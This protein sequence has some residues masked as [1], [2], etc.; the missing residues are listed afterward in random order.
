MLGPDGEIK[1]KSGGF[2]KHS[3]IDTDW[4]CYSI[5]ADGNV[6]VLSQLDK[7]FCFISGMGPHGK[8]YYCGILTN[9]W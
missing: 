4:L 1:G 6:A 9:T 7:A 2:G 5:S 3:T 8:S